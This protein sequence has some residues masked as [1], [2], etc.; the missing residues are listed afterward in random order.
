MK[1]EIDEAILY[2]MER[3]DSLI[4]REALVRLAAELYEPTV[5]GFYYSLSAKN[6]EADHQQS[7]AYLPAHEKSLRDAPKLQ[8]QERYSQ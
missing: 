5:G 1:N 6:N 8:V 7:S 2:E 3:L 4:E